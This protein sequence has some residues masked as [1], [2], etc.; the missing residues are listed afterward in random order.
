MSHTNTVET[1]N[2]VVTGA[3]AQPMT[4]PTPDDT[5]GST[6]M[7]Q[8]LSVSAQQDV[9]VVITESSAAAVDAELATAA[10]L[11]RQQICHQP[12]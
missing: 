7:P 8:S 12:Q 4:K 6:L 5:V 2:A 3:L 11:Q 10:T 9:N 1:G